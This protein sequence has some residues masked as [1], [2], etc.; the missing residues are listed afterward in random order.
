MNQ[1]EYVKLKEI[2]IYEDFLTK[3][4]INLLIYIFSSK[5]P[6]IPNK[7]IEQLWRLGFTKTKA[8][9][10]VDNF[11]TISW[12]GTWQTFELKM[13]LVILIIKKL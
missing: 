7:D 8:I 10:N 4:F 9:C 11:R 2:S 13:I 3:D 6:Y 1:K 5:C 12:T